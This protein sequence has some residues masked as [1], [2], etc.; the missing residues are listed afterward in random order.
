MQLNSTSYIVGFAT[1]VCVFCS[2]L[3]STAAVS[4]QSRQER[5]AKLYK[6]KNVL[7]A[8]GLI[9]P[10]DSVSDQEALKMFEENVEVRLVNLETGEYAENAPVDP[11]EY[12]QRAARDDPAQSREAPPNSAQVKRIPKVGAVYLIRTGGQVD[13]VV[14]PVEGYGLWG[15]LYGFLALE[16][17]ANT[18]RG[19]TYYEHKE[20][21]GLGGEV[22]NPRWKSLWPGRKAYD[23]RGEPAI[24]VV[25]GPAGPVSEAPHHIDGL[26]GATITSNGVTHMMEFWLGP[27]GYGPFLK[28]FRDEG[29]A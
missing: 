28:K 10:G 4:L 12:D 15:T 14:I 13:A 24:R 2:I 22:D 5:N 18:I 21:P 26:A 9:K 7:I 6:Q 16:N 27:N 1:A 20:T 8:A 29:G 11:D 19:I 3:V 23:E 25:K 17:D